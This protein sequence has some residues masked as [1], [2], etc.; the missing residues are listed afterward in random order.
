[1]A[2]QEAPS[3]NQEPQEQQEQHG[4]NS[5]QPQNFHNRRPMPL[6][7]FCLLGQC[8]QSNRKY[9]HLPPHVLPLNKQTAKFVY[10]A[11]ARNDEDVA[12]SVQK[13]VEPSTNNVRSG[14]F[15]SQRP[16]RSYAN[17]VRSNSQHSDGH[18][19]FSRPPR[20]YQTRR[21]PFESTSHQSAQ[22]NQP[23]EKIEMVD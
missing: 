14:S 3:S 16:P 22:D 15:Q 20:S 9:W 21:Q 7:K 19:R 11:F 12:P 5:N 6:C 18:Q 17:N 8:S 13:V 4:S 23:T 10:D 1:M 2:D